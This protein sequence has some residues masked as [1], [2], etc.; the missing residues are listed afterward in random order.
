M[1]MIEWFLNRK[2]KEH[3][4]TTAW[5]VD[6]SK[7]LQWDAFV[8]KPAD[9]SMHC[10]E[11]VL[12]RSRFC[13]SKSSLRQSMLIWEECSLIVC[14][15]FNQRHSIP[16]SAIPC[17]AY[18][19]ALDD[20][21]SEKLPVAEKG[22]SNEILAIQDSTED[23]SVVAHSKSEVVLGRRKHEEPEDGEIEC[24]PEVKKA[25]LDVGNESAF[26]ESA[27][28]NEDL[29]DSSK[30]IANGNPVRSCPL[31]K[32]PLGSVLPQAKVASAKESHVLNSV[33][34]LELRNYCEKLFLFKKVK[35]KRFK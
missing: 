7:T 31:S 1:I 11:A 33:A 12:F 13:S 29:T 30:G 4:R 32:L 25:H 5:W 18:R 20:E 26:N 15:F 10:G 34:P 17:L 16:L 3:F 23:G 6:R 28:S 8:F 35:C 24:E 19:R 22:G 9:K 21:S 2:R 27:Q 14:L